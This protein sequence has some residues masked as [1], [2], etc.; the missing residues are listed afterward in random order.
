MPC[1]SLKI[2]D[3]EYAYRSG[4]IT[5][6]DLVREIYHRIAQ[7]KDN[8]IWITLVPEAQAI[9]AAESVMAASDPNRPLYG[10]PFAVKDNIDVAG[11]L[12]TAACPAFAYTPAKHATVVSKLIEAGALLIGK[13]NLDQFATGLSGTR[14]PYGEVHNAIDPDF[15]SGG[16]SSGSAVAVALNLVSFALGT[17]TAGSGRVPAAFNHIVGLKPTR[18]RVSAAGVLPAC[19]SLDCVSIFSATVADAG[20][21]LAVIE[22]DD[23]LDPYS[24][25]MFDQALSHARKF[26][27]GVPSEA[28]L[29]WFGDTEYARLY[30][31]AVVRFASL[32][33]EAV[34]I[35]YTPFR[36]AAQMLY[37]GA[38]VAER[39]A[40]IQGFFDAHGDELLPVTRQVIGN[41]KD[42]LGA[43][44]FHAQHRISALCSE[45]ARTWTTIDLLLLPTAPTI[46]R[47][48][49]MLSDPIELNA[50][51]GI[52]TNFVNL[53]DLCA[54]ALPAGVRGDGLPFGVTLIAPAGR[55]C[56]LLE[57]GQAW[58]T[59]RSYDV[60]IDN[61]ALQ[62]DSTVKVAVVGAHLSGQPLN[63]QLTQRGGKQLRAAHTAAHY[64]LYALAHTAPPK[65]GLMR[66]AEGGK[67]IEVEVWSLPLSHYGSFVAEIPGPLGIG[68]L[69]L[70]DG[71]RV[72]GFVCEPY[73]LA[74][75]LDITAYGGW[76]GYLASC[77]SDSTTSKESS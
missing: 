8:P 48:R 25:V 42:V 23:D 39:Y 37:G 31:D 50:R 69:E 55:D 19:Q 33:G 4:D 10:I 13:T 77:K 11:L 52:Y 20:K 16:S 43:D 34:E 40:A 64:R 27:F 66:V 65:P 45:A 53:F 30:R 22:G 51:L 24:R 68:T 38:L 49:E 59:G 75:A 76:R 60:R 63:W 9:A 29:E 62:A 14:S 67:P 18:G 47:R 70:E 21:V 74:G 61:A 57:I 26:R 7:H 3:L 2:E 17:D 58:Q 56:Y 73:A 5:P 36:E 32:G 1:L 28:D 41:G 35:D 54:L 15:I 46:Y 72:Q 71:E 12:T 6:V 44:V